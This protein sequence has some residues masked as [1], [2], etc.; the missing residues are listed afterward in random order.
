[1]EAPPDFAAGAG[2]AA[3]ESLARLER[4]RAGG[5]R[6]P[7]F[8]R[9][10][11]R[12]LPRRGAASD[13]SGRLWGSRNEEGT[14]LRVELNPGTPRERRYLLQ[15]GPKASVWMWKAGGA[16]PERADDFAP[17]LPGL[18]L[19]PFDLEMP[20]LYWPSPETEGIRRMLG[21]PAELFVFRAP[22]GAGPGEPGV[23]A[24][25]AYLDTQYAAPVQIERL[26]ADGRVLSTFSLVDLKK[27]GDQWMP[28]D[29]EVRDEDSRDKT[30]FTMVGAALGL[31]IEPE[32]FAPGA[33]DKPG[34]PPPAE[35]IREFGP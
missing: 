23:A 13:F 9:F 2:P 24:V 29:I 33:L 32:F 16:G 6:A 1:L 14:V 15:N 25:R 27:V 30:R 8:L 4:F 31:S 26:A 21:R 5:P 17:L 28:R 20:F 3:G 18:D 7:Y 11:L 10:R 35:S 34:V 19:T 12:E 22:S